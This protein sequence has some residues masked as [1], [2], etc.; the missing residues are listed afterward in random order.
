MKQ[1]DKEAYYKLMLSKNQFQIEFSIKMIE[2]VKKI[3]L[4]EYPDIENLQLTFDYSTLD[5]ITEWDGGR[6][7]DQQMAKIMNE[8]DDIIAKASQTYGK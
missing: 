8:L 7:T 3:I 6:P 4:N 2:L 1:Q 5:V